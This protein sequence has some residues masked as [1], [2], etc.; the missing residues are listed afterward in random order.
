MHIAVAAIADDCTLQLF[1]LLYAWLT[2][3]KFSSNT[4]WALGQW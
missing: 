3:L 1:T 2:Q 4:I